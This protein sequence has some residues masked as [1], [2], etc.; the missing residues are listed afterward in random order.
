MG[1]VENTISYCCVWKDG[2]VLYTYNS[3]EKEIENLAALCL[4]MTPPYHRWYFQT[5]GKRTFGFLMEEGYVYFAIVNE[6]LGNSQVLRFLQRLRDEFKRIG[7]RGSTRSVSSL[8]SLCLQEQLLPVV[9]RLVASLEQVSGTNTEWPTDNTLPYQGERERSPCNTANGHIESGASTNA[10]LLG[11][12]SKQDK[13]KM[14]DHAIAMREIEINEH[15][16]STD[17]GVKIDLDNQGTS[18]SP[19]QQDFGSPRIK[20]TS[21]MLRKKWCRQ[22]RIVLAVDA[23]ICIVLFIIWLVICHGTECIH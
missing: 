1:S 23:A 19:L 18:A 2:R 7:K 20:S 8:N 6:S 16:R 3:G 21:Q 15:R 10:P 5:M 9:H 13:K 22:V 17:G 11:K 12:P 14:K 4:E